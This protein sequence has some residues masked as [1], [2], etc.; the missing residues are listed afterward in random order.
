MEALS[1]H[2]FRKY[3]TPDVLS[4]P[5]SL[6]NGVA[7]HHG[8][9]EAFDLP[10]VA[11][12]TLTQDP[13]QQG[14]GIQCFLSKFGKRAAEG[15]SYSLAVEAYALPRPKHVLLGG[16]QER[17]ES[18]VIRFDETLQ[19]QQRDVTPGL[20]QPQRR[21]AEWYLNEFFEVVARI[22]HRPSPLRQVW[23]VLAY[24]VLDHRLIGTD[25]ECCPVDEEEE[26]DCL[27]RGDGCLG[28]T[29]IKVI[30]DDHQLV[31]VCGRQEL[32]ELSP[33]FVHVLGELL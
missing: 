33:E 32:F 15:A 18:F 25:H 6:C 21:D 27:K 12:G 8:V 10:G 28:Q 1:Q 4:K 5:S 7:Q 31:N 2:D 26:A 29:S 24:R 30:N 16:I 13:G 19:L 23:E 20:R 3:W 22:G 11:A 9:Q 17:L 14:T